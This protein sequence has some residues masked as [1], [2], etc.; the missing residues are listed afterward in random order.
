MLHHYTY[1]HEYAIL[2]AAIAT[3]YSIAMYRI[4]V[5]FFSAL[6]CASQPTNEF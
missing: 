3:K 4:C 6:S 5:C 1:T 2:L